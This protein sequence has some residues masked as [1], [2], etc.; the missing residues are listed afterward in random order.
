MSVLDQLMR[1]K[2]VIQGAESYIP[3]GSVGTTELEDES[4]V[5]GDIADAAVTADKIAAAVAGDG[6]AGGAG[7]ALSVDVDDS[8]L[9]IVAN[10][11]AIKDGGVTGAKIAAAAAGDGLTGGGGSALAVDPDGTGLEIS[12]GK[13]ALKDAGVT[14]ARLN[15]DA[16]KHV[17]TVPM[18]TLPVNDTKYVG[19]MAVPAGVSIIITKVVLSAQTIPVDADG[20]CLVSLTNYDSGST[21]DDV[22]VAAWDAEGLVAK[23][24]TQMT[25]IV[26]GDINT[27]AE[28]DFLYVTLVNNSAVIDQDWL[29]ACMT[30]EYQEV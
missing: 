28:N 13:V 20:T 14:K 5:V 12:G 26:A 19:V 16:K 11:V 1:E 2:N 17:I 10:K 21:T 3:A 23:V 15:A 30:I 4:I 9:A 24:G 22:L 29:G 18:P 25:V 27:I 8:T 6:I 7:T